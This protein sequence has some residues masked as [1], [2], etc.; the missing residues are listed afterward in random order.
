MTCDDVAMHEESHLI[1]S[2]VQKTIR[3]FA[4]AENG[5][6][7]DCKNTKK[8]QHFV[9]SSNLQSAGHQIDYFDAEKSGKNDERTACIKH[10]VAAGVTTKQE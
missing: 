5:L 3:I 10:G 2:E 8:R 7:Y 4:L 6:E 1:Q 9:K